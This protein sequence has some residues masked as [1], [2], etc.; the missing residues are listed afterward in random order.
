[1][2]SCVGAAVAVGI[3]SFFIRWV[4]IQRNLKFKQLISVEMA[5]A[6]ASVVPVPSSLR[7][8]APSPH[9]IAPFTPHMEMVAMS[10][11][12]P[13]SAPV[14]FVQQPVPVVPTPVIVAPAIAGGG[15]GDFTLAQQQLAQQQALLQ[16]QI[17]E[18]QRQLQQHKTN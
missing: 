11:P 14:F 18:L 13:Q 10:T 4:M 12:Q 6:M 9:K 3:L 17:N 5:Q 16:Q 2:G 1:M 15:G 7:T 8:P